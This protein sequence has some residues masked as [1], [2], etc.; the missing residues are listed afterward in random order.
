MDYVLNKLRAQVAVLKDV[1][2]DYPTSTIDN[3]VK[4]IE[5]RIKHIENENK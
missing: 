1:M 5:S 2:K 3:A 4:Q